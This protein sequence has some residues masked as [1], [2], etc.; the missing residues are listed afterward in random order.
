MFMIWHRLRR[1]VVSLF[2]IKICLF[3][4]CFPLR[5]RPLYAISDGEV[6]PVEFGAPV[7]GTLADYAEF[8][9]M[10]HNKILHR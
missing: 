2:F 6:D 5:E 8:R 10:R 7:F 4:G 1:F 3:A 9:R